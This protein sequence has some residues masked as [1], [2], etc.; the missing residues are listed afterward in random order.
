LQRGRGAAPVRVDQTEHLLPFERHRD[1]IPH[2]EDLKRI[3]HVHDARHAWK[4]ALRKRVGR[5]SLFEFSRRFMAA[6]G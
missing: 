2:L 6:H 3:F 4:E 1:G 5:R